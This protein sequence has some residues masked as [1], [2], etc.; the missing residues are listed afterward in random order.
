L[1]FALRKPK[2]ELT[3]IGLAIAAAFPVVALIGGLGR[4][5]LWYIVLMALVLTASLVRRI[6]T[7]WR[8]G[9]LRRAV[10]CVAGV[11]LRMTFLRAVGLAM[12]RIKTDQGEQAGGGIGPQSDVGEDDRG[13]LGCGAVPL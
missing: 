6:A 1:V 8:S 9:N 12:G 10:C 5:V 13:G 3:T 11:K 7:L 2:D 4:G